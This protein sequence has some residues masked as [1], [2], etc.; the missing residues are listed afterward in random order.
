MSAV[1]LR[2]PLAVRPVA[3]AAVAAVVLACAPRAE[4]IPAFARRYQFSCSTCHSPVPRLKP[5]GEAFAARGFRLEDPSQEPPRATY[6]TGDPTLRLLREV[7]LAIRAEGYASWK[8][9]A[10]AEVDGEWPWAFKVLSGG[11]LSEKISYYAYFIMEKGGVEGLEDAYLQF[12]KPFGLPFNLLAGQFQV[13]DPLFKRELR[14]ERFDYEI[15]RTRVGN[16]PITLTY[17]RGI[18]AGWTFPGAI[19]SVFQVVNG[20][21]IDHAD[22]EDNFDNDGPKNVSLR[23][24]RVF[25]DK[26]RVGVFSY[27][28]TSDLGDASNRTYY[29]GPDAVVTFSDRLQ[30]NLQYLER[31]DDNP[32][33]TGASGPDW[34]TR[35]GFAEL[36]YLPR[37]ADGPYALAALYN[38]VSSD[39]V[40][41]RRET[42]SGT[43]NY[44]L[45]RNI[46][47]MVEA[48]RDIEHKAGRLSLG[49]SAAF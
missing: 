8:H 33:F 12:N 49:I 46:R 34:E 31:R 38:K 32:L 23:L 44:L 40:A 17:D 24:A 1:A 20:N 5:F 30:L 45:A 43:L 29:L 47:A 14:L 22:D 28:G 11:P 13:S 39:D 16:S 21:G 48:G 37:G 10:A 7:P 6:D 4:A 3:A 18:V 35:G 36:V 19:D 9:D 26:V 27:W 42:V 15:F 2:S 41:A 25:A